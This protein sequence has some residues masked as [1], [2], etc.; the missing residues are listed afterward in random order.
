MQRYFIELAYNG[1]DFFGWQ[2]QPREISVQ[3]VIEEQL[4]KLHSNTPIKVLGCGRTDTGVHAKHFILHTDLPEIKDKGLFLNKMNKMLPKAIVFY[5]VYEVDADK[6][7]RFDAKS[8][9][10]RYFIHREKN[11]FLVDQ[12]WLLKKELNLDKMN[13]AANY[14][15]G[16][17]D[18]TSLSKAHT[19]VK[20]NICNITKAKW[21]KVSEN[22]C[23]FEITANRF[24]RNMVRATVGT[25]VEI[26]LGKVQPEE[27]KIILE[28]KDRQVA[29]ISAPAGGLFLWEVIY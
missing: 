23:Y 7:A 29:A 8:R 13:E 12:S 9:T 26:G 2:R 5:K 25:L 21:V 19:D 10:Y 14:L 27:M 15:L 22:D 16:E 24:L 20:T 28:K 11:P 17:Q 6:H 1:T 4:S 18:F 3:E